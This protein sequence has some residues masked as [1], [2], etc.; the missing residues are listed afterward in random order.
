M[1]V[2]ISD[3]ESSI[4]QCRVGILYKTIELPGRAP[5]LLGTVNNPLVDQEKLDTLLAIKKAEWHSRNIGKKKHFQQCQQS[6][7]NFALTPP[8]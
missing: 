7:S 5:Q 3:L 6:A 4:N 2:L 8:K 1:R